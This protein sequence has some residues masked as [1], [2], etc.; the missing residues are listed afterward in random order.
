MPVTAPVSII[1]IIKEG[2][3]RGRNRSYCFTEGGR[4]IL[5]KKGKKVSLFFCREQEEQRRGRAPFPG[6]RENAVTHSTFAEEMERRGKKK[7]IFLF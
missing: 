2:E 4:I 5:V 3:K 7:P 1:M 6:R